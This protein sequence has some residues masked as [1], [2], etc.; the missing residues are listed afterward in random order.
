LDTRLLLADLYVKSGR[1]KDAAAIYEAA[2]AS[3]ELPGERRA[4]VQGRL[5]MLQR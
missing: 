1:M 4:Y 3:P 2:A 5:R